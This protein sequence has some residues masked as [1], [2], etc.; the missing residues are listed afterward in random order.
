MIKAWCIEVFIHA[1][2]HTPEF[3][4]Y[5]LILDLHWGNI[6]IDFSFLHTSGVVNLMECFSFPTCTPFVSVL[7]GQHPPSVPHYIVEKCR[8]DLSLASLI[9]EHSS[10]VVAKIIDFGACLCPEMDLPPMLKVGNGPA[11][12]CTALSPST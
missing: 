4:T 1:H 11:A 7:P 5:H 8:P 12:G 2:T 10:S 3:V 9:H 6:A